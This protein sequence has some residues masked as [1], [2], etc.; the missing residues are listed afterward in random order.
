MNEA[1]IIYFLMLCCRKVRHAAAVALSHMTSSTHAQSQEQFLRHI[2]NF[3]RLSLSAAAVTGADEA[4]LSTDADDAADTAV[5][6]FTQD[7]VAVIRKIGQR[8]EITNDLTSFEY[9]LYKCTFFCV[10]AFDHK[11][12]WVW[13]YS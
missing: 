8:H 13:S 10:F 1:A 4:V 12:Q 5:V 9:M 6:Q 3:Y 7:I 11:V 2:S